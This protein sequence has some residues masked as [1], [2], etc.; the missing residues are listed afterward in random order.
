MKKTMKLLLGLP[1]LLAFLVVGCSLDTPD[2]STDLV[3]PTGDHTFANYASIGNSLTAGYMDGGVCINGQ[4]SSYPR[5]I[6]QQMGLDVSVGNS[7]FTQ[8]YVAMPGIGGSDENDPSKVNGVLYF[9]GSGLEVLGQHNL[10]D[11]A[12]PSSP[13]NPLILRTLPVPYDNHGVPGAYL[14]D[15]MYA[16]DALTSAKVGN[17]FFLFNNRASLFGNSTVAPSAGPPPSP[18]WETSS[19]FWQTIAAGP[20]LTT[21]WIGNNDILYGATDGDP[22]IGENITDAATFE[23]E[24]AAMLGTLAG[25]LV[26]RTGFP[27]TIVVANIPSISTIPYFIAKDFFEFNVVGQGA[28]SA[29]WPGGYDESDIAMMTF[30]VMRWMTSPGEGLIIE[31]G[32]VVGYNSMPSEFTLTT[33]EVGVVETQIATFNAIIA[34]VSAEVAGSGYAKIGVVDA[35]A[36]MTEI[37]SGT[38]EAGPMAATHFLFLV[39]QDNPLTPDVVDPLTIEQAAAATLFSL[40]GVH[41]N[42]RGYGVVANAF[43]EKINE[44]Q[45]TNIADVDWNALVW[46]PTYGATLET[47]ALNGK[48][49]TVS[50]QAAHAMGSIWQ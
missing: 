33:T 14:H 9:D 8:P 2:Q 30:P 17:S 5:L 25:A 13:N 28:V 48:L 16:Y 6:A 32:E 49:P 3:A 22:A 10:V 50:S 19:M 37:A 35:N 42:N 45:G 38:H 31:E 26:Q 27:T 1:I 21:V 29:P 4:L 12:D 34:G 41:P 36:L 7:E 24:F 40:D 44:L 43:I 15:V 23:A 47:K 39:G 18:G 20:S 11:I 46:D